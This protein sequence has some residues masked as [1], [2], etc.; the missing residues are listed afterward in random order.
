MHCE[1]LNYED[2]Y[3]ES[4]DNPEAF[5]GKAAKGI[6]WERK[7]DCVLDNSHSPFVKW[8]SGAVLNTC[9]NAVDF[10]VENGRGTQ[11]AVIYDSPVTDTI[12]E[13]T[14]AEL[15]ARVSRIAG[16][17]KELWVVKGDT[18]LIYMPMIPETRMAML[19]PV[20]FI[21]RPPTWAGKWGTLTLCMAHC[22]RAPRPSSSKVSRSA[23]LIPGHSG[24]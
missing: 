17:L 14:Y 10:H 23:H 12:R 20:M 9:Y 4:L 7:W 8:F 3:R 19:T 21:G 5:W 24:A 15:K 22:C 18:V 16:F 11:N 13:F 1:K 6:R 2:L